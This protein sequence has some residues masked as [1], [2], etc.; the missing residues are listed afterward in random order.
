MLIARDSE[1]IRRSD[2]V[3]GT[4]KLLSKPGVMVAAALTVRLVYLY[5]FFHNQPVPVGNRYV[6]GYETGSIAASLAAGHGYSSPLYVSSGPTAWITPV[7]PLVLA[8]IFEIFGIYT[9][10][11][12]IVIRCFNILCSGL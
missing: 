2:W 6:I 7:Y 4:A 5:Q 11:A 8:G 3:R 12:S 10:N 9:L 1:R